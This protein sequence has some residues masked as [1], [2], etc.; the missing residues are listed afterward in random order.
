MASL[1]IGNRDHYYLHYAEAHLIRFREGAKQMGLALPWSIEEMLAGIKELL[2]REPAGTKYVRPIAY[3][4]APELWITGSEGRLADVSIFTVSIDTYRDVDTPIV[5][6]LSPIERIS[7]RSIPSQIKVSG[8]T[9]TAFSPEELRNWPATMTPS[10]STAK[11]VLPKRRRPTCSSSLAMRLLD[12]ATQSRL[13]PGNHPEGHFGIGSFERHQGKGDGSEMPRSGE[14]R[15]C[16]LM[17][18]PDGNP[19]LVG[20]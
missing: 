15:R 14:Y 5:C 7:S 13:V 8:L 9:S 20:P 17:L 12:T 18:D 11:A 1:P 6:Q 2:N 3:W 4:R 19:W 10:C 16:L